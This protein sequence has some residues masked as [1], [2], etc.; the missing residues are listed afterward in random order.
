MK[1]GDDLCEHCSI[2]TFGYCRSTHRQARGK[3]ICGP[4]DHAVA[5]G[6]VIV[7]AHAGRV[8]GGDQE[9]RGGSRGWRTDEQGPHEPTGTVLFLGPSAGLLS[10]HLLPFF[11]PI[12]PYVFVPGWLV[13]LAPAPVFRWSLAWRWR[14]SFHD[15]QCRSQQRAHGPT[16]LESALA[17]HIPVC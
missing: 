9:D 17:C 8:A 14:S 2:A 1:S 15:V 3:E 11:A 4:Q 6:A 12:W 5:A 13:F 10:W 16:H 7:H